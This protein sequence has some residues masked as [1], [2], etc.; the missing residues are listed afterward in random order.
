GVSPAKISSVISSGVKACSSC[1]LPLEP[2]PFCEALFSSSE[3][4]LQAARINPT[5]SK[6]AD[7]NIFMRVISYPPPDTRLLR[8]GSSSGLHLL[9]S[10]QRALLRPYRRS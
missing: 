9:S 7:G 2:P 3:S 1:E 6:A 5:E 4:E 10:I 8:G